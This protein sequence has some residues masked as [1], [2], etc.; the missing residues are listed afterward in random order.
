MSKIPLEFE[1]ERLEGH[2]RS[3]R[4]EDEALKVLAS[5][6]E[7]DKSVHQG[8]ADSYRTLRGTE[9][10]KTKVVARR[11]KIEEPSRLVIQRKPPEE[12]LRIEMLKHVV[13]VDDLA[14]EMFHGS[15]VSA[16]NVLFEDS[17]SE[18]MRALDVG[19]CAASPVVLT[20]RSHVTAPRV[21]AARTQIGHTVKRV[22]RLHFDLQQRPSKIREQARCEGDIEITQNKLHGSAF[23]FDFGTLYS[24]WPY[25]REGSYLRRTAIAVQET[26]TT[27]R[28]DN[29][30]RMRKDRTAIQGK[31]NGSTRRHASDIQA[32]TIEGPTMVYDRRSCGSTA[33]RARAL[34]VDSRRQSS[35]IRDPTSTNAEPNGSRFCSSFK[36]FYLHR[37]YTRD[38]GYMRRGAS[39]SQARARRTPSTVYEEEDVLPLVY[40]KVTVAI[41]GRAMLRLEPR[42]IHHVLRPLTALRKRVNTTSYYRF[43]RSYLHYKV[44]SMEPSIRGDVFMH[45]KRN[46][47]SFYLSCATSCLQEHCSRIDDDFEETT[48]RPTERQVQRL[49]G[50]TTELARQLRIELQQQSSGI[51]DLTSVEMEP[52]GSCLYFCFAAFYLQIHH[53]RVDGNLE[54]RTH[55]HTAQQVHQPRKA[56]GNEFEATLRNCAQDLIR[57]ATQWRGLESQRDARHVESV[58][59]VPSGLEGPSF[60]F[61][62]RAI[63]LKLYHFREYKF[64]QSIDESSSNGAPT[65]RRLTSRSMAVSL[66]VEDAY[67]VIDR[68]RFIGRHT[69]KQL[70]KGNSVSVLDIVQRHHDIPVYLGNVTDERDIKA[71]KTPP[72]M[73]GPTSKPPEPSSM[74]LSQ[75]GVTFGG[76]DIVNVDERVPYLEKPF[77]VYNDSKAQG[78]KIVLEANGKDGLWTVALRP[79]GMFGPTDS[80]IS[81]SGGLFDCTYDGNI[82]HTILLAGGGLI[83]PPSYSSATSSEPRLDPEGATAKLNESLH[84]VLP[85]VCATTECHHVTQT[86]G[87]YVAPPPNTEPILSV[88]N[89]PFDPHE[90]KHPISGSRSGVCGREIRC[91]R[92]SASA[93][94][95]ARV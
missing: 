81:G 61:F 56:T 24:H 67:P 16:I 5:G 4:V 60:S 49:H 87:P 27:A 31:K 57:I 50:S 43:H 83:P 73:P 22:R 84:R 52:D 40:I 70:A 66:Q 41:L 9:Y 37:F 90:R 3:T 47:P 6:H 55:R 32:A 94:Q 79:A 2:A 8:N 48:Y 26:T 15:A 75:R 77:D 46:G 17:S 69:I 85:P 39:D 59:I 12:A 68:S 64:L 14:L 53:S 63:Y 11:I 74:R 20:K 91:L 86:L 78:E 10:I 44:K 45:L 29:D 80:Q 21:V 54:E 71:R 89:T 25:F 36:P 88:F 38:N 18:L 30:R 72:S 65:V 1:T 93:V 95:V 42:F 23:R 82:A 33:R 76:T 13:R 19:T 51:Q 7:A 35:R 62:F 92:R 58:E 34:Q 28:L